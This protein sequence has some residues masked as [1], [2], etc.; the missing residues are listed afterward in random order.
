MA[1][2]STGW[3]PQSHRG[4]TLG[5][6]DAYLNKDMFSDSNIWSAMYLQRDCSS[7]ELSVYSVP[8]VGSLS[9]VRV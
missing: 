9:L 3:L 5:R 7:V 2:Y 4:I 1:T 6:L 8:Q